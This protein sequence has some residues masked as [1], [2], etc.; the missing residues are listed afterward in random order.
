M[1]Q[2]A[3]ARTA[4]LP[5]MAEVAGAQAILAE[6]RGRAEALFTAAAAEA[7]HL[8]ITLRPK[9]VVHGV[10]MRLEAAEQVARQKL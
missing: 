1:G 9:L 6:V 2:K 4:T 10:R 8:E 7:E 3:E 5:N